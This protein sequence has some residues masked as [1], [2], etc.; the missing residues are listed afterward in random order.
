MSIFTLAVLVG[1]I[2][3]Q[4][5]WLMILNAKVTQ[6]YKICFALNDLNEKHLAAEKDLVEI[7]KLHDK[8]F[9]ALQEFFGDVLKVAKEESSD[10]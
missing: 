3:F 1:V 9:E 6:L 2:I 7:V 5:V 4:E 10:E 8:S